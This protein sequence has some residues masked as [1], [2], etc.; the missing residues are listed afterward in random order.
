MVDASIGEQRAGSLASRW[1]V[2]EGTKTY[3]LLAV[4]PLIVWYAVC[5]TA[6]LPALLQQIAGMQ[7]STIDLLA[8]SSVAAK[9]ASLIFITVL[10]ALLIFRHTPKAKAPGL[11]PRIMAL[12]G[13]YLGVGIVLLPS[14]QLSA[15]LYLTATLLIVSG[16]A[17]ALYSALKLG[18]SI[19]MMSEARRLVTCGP[20]AL[21]RHPLYLGEG[22]ALA[23]LTLQFL[24]PWAVVIFA[25]QCACQMQRMKNEERVLLRAFPEYR[26]YMNRTA[27]L[28]PHLY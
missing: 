28:V 12:G 11:I 2:L 8:I 27:R 25:L 15:R 16:T 4:T 14:I 21:V 23:G 7:L 1:K 24:S 19:S 20:Y 10:I 18:R 17:F 5:V 3:D 6:R 22:I 9:S 13:T 26:N